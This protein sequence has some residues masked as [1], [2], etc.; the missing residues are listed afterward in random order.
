MVYG[1]LYVAFSE[2]DTAPVKR[3]KTANTSKEQ[4]CDNRQVKIQVAGLSLG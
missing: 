3:D 1:C 2:C 4:V